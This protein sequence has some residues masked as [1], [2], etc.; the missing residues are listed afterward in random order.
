MYDSNLSSEEI[1]V[2]SI[3]HEELTIPKIIA[4]ARHFAQVE[5][6][7]GEK[8]KRVEQIRK[9]IE[10]HWMGHS[11]EPRY[12]FNTGVGSLK[13]VRISPEQIEKFQELYVKSHCVGV[14][15]PLDI[16]TVR[17]AMLL[18]TNALAKGYSGVRA[19]V[20]DKLIEMLN[21]RIHPLVPEQGSLG[22]SGD[23]APLTHILSVM[24]G[25]EEAEIWVNNEKLKVK[26]IK[27]SSGVI[28]FT[29]DGEPVEFQTIRLQGKEAVSLTNSTAM[30]LSMAVHLI[31]DVEILL[32]NADIATALSLEAMMCEKDAFAEEL[33]DLRNQAGQITTAKNIRRLTENSRR[34]TPEARL[35]YFKTTTEKKIKENLQGSE[36]ADATELI[37]KYKLQFEYDKNRIQDA[38]SLRCVPQVH[39]ACKDAFHYVKN[40]IER[41]IAAVTD[42]PVIFPN[43]TG[44]GFEVKSG[45]NFHG[46]P[47]ALALDFLA[48]ATAEIGSISERRVF[49]L[50]SPSMSFG[51]PRN[52]TGGEPGLN[53]GYMLLQYTAAQLVSENKILAHPASVDSIPTSD[54]QED[55]VSMGFTAARKAL[56]IFQNVENLMAIEHLCAVQALHLSC[57]NDQVNLNAFPLGK[58]TAAAFEFLKN[59]NVETENGAD[60]PFDFVKDDTYLHSKIVRMQDVLS[61]GKLVLAIEKILELQ[62]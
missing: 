28:R 35:A 13:N 26:K 22:A 41:E 9:Y 55:H 34:M 59:I 15:E 46:E 21:K 1:K 16:E 32:K 10:D 14:G 18:Q 44:D 8:R 57:L 25:E 49:R 24:V 5:S 33:H 2:V 61:S 20:I 17:G 27:N 60:A 7:A 29:Q 45:G 51:L 4:V 12:G 39:G 54:N 11:A 56:K 50:L 37:Q 53:S 43:K 48:L 23:L 3:N 6:F 52:L 19:L 31:H 47:L 38:Y 58:G 36:L 40:I 30:M 62:V 42:N